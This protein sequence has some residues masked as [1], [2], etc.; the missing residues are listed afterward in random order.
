MG[1]DRHAAAVPGVV[2]GHEHPAERGGRSQDGEQRC[3]GLHPLQALG[4]AAGEVCAPLKRRSHAFERAVAVAQVPIIRDR[5]RLTRR[6]GACLVHRHQARVVWK[7]QRGEQRHV[8]ERE[9][10]GVGANRDRQDGD[11]GEREA[12]MSAQGANGGAE[13]VD[14]TH[15]AGYAR[16][17]RSG[18]RNVLLRTMKIAHTLASGFRGFRLQPEGCVKR[19]NLPRQPQ[20]SG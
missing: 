7:R 19:S 12:R 10:G 14:D 1:Q 2:L 13:V 16:A 18:Q 20:P 17:I 3:R 8:D 6:V 5:Q 9:H 15:G 11:D 4:F